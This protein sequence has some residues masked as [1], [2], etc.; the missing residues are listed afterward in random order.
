MIL[1]DSILES[2]AWPREGP[3]EIV[4]KQEKTW[5]GFSSKRN[6]KKKNK[7]IKTVQKFKER[8]KQQMKD[9]SPLYFP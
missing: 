1:A 7:S 4:Y 8:L 3:G 2:P 9:I 6:R 5:L